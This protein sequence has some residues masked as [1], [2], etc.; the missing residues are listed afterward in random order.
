MVKALLMSKLARLGC[1][2]GAATNCILARPT[3]AS[4]SPKSHSL[5]WTRYRRIHPVSSVVTHGYHY[6]CGKPTLAG[7]EWPPGT[8]RSVPASWL[9][10]AQPLPSLTGE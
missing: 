5:V 8:A 7:V 1:T 2:A 4:N 6:A 10:D 9:Q 3:T